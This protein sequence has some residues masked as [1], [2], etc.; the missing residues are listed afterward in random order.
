[1]TSA[2][3]AVRVSREA[4]WRAWTPPGRPPRAGW[5]AV[6]ALH[7]FGLDLPAW[8]IVLRRRF[9][10]AP[11]AWILPRAP[12]R[13]YRKGEVGFGWLVSS[14]TNADREGMPSSERSVMR[15]ENAACRALPIDRRRLAL[16]GFSQ[17]GFMAGV[18]ALRNPRR[19]RRAAVLGGYINPALVPLGLARARGMRIAFLHGRSDRTV[20]AER[21]RESVAILRAAG[22]DGSLTELAGGHTL[23]PA[24]AAA[25]RDFLA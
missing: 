24:M 6:V 20:P 8:E 7:G 14:P 2:R 11:W 13:V 16:M 12:W 22:I 23:T 3:G 10:G 5:P 19:W 21:A 17:G 25:C 15:S 9:P 1:M 4:P 18:L